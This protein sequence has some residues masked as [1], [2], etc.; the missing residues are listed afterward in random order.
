MPDNASKV[1]YVVKMEDSRPS[2]NTVGMADNV[3]CGDPKIQ[4]AAEG[5][6]ANLET[7]NNGSYWK[8]SLI[9]NAHC[10]KFQI[11]RDFT[12]AHDVI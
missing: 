10:S 5:A 7:V 3:S 4:D 1:V 12:E 6:P 2:M 8:D 9:M 11:A